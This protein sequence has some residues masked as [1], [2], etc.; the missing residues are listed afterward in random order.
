[1]HLTGI[2][3]QVR[4]WSAIRE[5]MEA[6]DIEA[7]AWF[8][9]ITV[10]LMAV[11]TPRLLFFA[12]GGFAFGFW[13]GLG[14]A[15]LAS[16]IASFLVFRIARWGGREWLV[17]SF[18]HRP[19]FARIVSVRP[20]VLSVALV[21][22]LPVSNL[23]INVGLALSR[24]RNR[25]FVWGTLIGFLPQG[26]VAVLLGSGVADD[27][28]LEGAVQLIA[29]GVIALLFLVYSLWRRHVARME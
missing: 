8:V 7:A 10:L 24:V 11:G 5:L 29:A 6:G 15:L 1:M 19:L 28:P 26:V 17:N 18:G 2:D 21:R 16:L 23:V 12:L 25:A 22:C 14:L 9:V 4:D 3:E 27:V 13:E 20:T